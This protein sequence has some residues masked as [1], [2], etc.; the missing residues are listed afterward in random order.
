MKFINLRI[1]MNFRKLGKT[2]FRVSEVSLGTWQVGGTWGQEFNERS[3]LK[4][5]NAAVDHGV[6]FIDTADIYSDGLSEKAVGEFIRNRPERICLASKCGKKTNPHSNEFYTSDKLRLYVEQSLKNTGLETLDLIQLHCAPPEVYDR[7]EIFGLF[8]RLK[9]EGKILNFGVSV[10]T[11]EEAQKA[12]RFENVTTVQLIF[13]M[14]RQRPAEEFFLEAFEKDIGLIIRVPLAS[15]L[16][17]GKY[18]KDTEF[19]PGDHRSYNREGEQFDKG[20]TFSGVPYDVGLRA[21]ARL[22]EL[23]PEPNK[24]AAF[25]IKWILMH[26]QV[27]C[28]IPGASKESQVTKNI[29]GSYLPPFSQGAMEAIKEVYDEEIKQHVHHLW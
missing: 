22:K 9:E 10:E 28:V 18:D 25:A 20:E 13:N 19:G 4:I 29:E 5:L 11:I 6:N 26:P 2:G 27:S 15:G 7:P 23:V 24:L 3:A 1:K 17:A 12:I 21:V 14:F 8:D 16:L